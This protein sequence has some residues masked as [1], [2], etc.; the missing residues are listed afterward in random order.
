MTTRADV[1]E[2]GYSW[3]HTRYQHQGRLKGVAVDCIG[4]IGMTALECGIEGAAEWRADPT[5]HSYGTTPEPEFLR[6]ACDRF[7][8][9]IAVGAARLGD[10]LVIAF[11]KQPQ[12]FAL[13]SH[14]DPTHVIHAYLQRRQVVEQSLPIAKSRV[15]CAYRFRGIA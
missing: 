7:L 3:L 11:P 2:V 5:M 6:S 9:P 12:H 13:I 4:L 1:V 14:D 8:D 10:I 15:L